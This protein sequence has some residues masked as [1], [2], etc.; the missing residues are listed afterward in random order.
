M[1][2][3][4][5]A[6]ELKAAELK[7]AE[8]K[9][10]E[11]KAA[12]LKGAELKGSA[13]LAH[14]GGLRDTPADWKR[15]ADYLGWLQVDEAGQKALDFDRLSKDWAAGDRE[16]KK[17][18]SKAHRYLAGAAELGEAGPRELAREVCG[19]VWTGCWRR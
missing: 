6:A 12:E 4:S 5:L 10:A 15:Y 13:A 18:L 16:F 14:A 17:E 11:L 8:L 7:A 3:K 1:L 2:Q 19:T 9:A